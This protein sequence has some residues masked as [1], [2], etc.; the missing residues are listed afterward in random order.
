MENA[1]KALI[2]AGS[3]LIAILIISLSIYTFKKFSEEAKPDFTKAEIGEFNSQILPFIG[4]R[5][6][7]AQVNSMIDKIRVLNISNVN[8]GKP[9]IQVDFPNGGLTRNGTFDTSMGNAKRVNTGHF[10]IVSIAEEDGFSSFGTISHI[11]VENPDE[12]P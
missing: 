11:I 12:A 3:I 4:Q 5:V 2:M 6:A 7:G 1:S 8:E 9:T 10:Y